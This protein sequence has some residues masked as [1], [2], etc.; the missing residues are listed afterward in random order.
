MV[1]NDIATWDLGEIIFSQDQRTIT[2]TTTSGFHAY[3]RLSGE[4]VCEGKLSSLDD[5]LGAHWVHE[6]SLQF[7]ISSKTDR[8]SMVSIKE[9]Q[10][11]SDP[12]LHLV[13]SFPILPQDGRFSF[14]PVSFHVSFVSVGKIVI[15][16]AQDSKILFQ[17]EGTKTSYTT[18]GYF[19]HDGSFCACGISSGELC[20]WK[21]TSTGYMLW[22]SL[23]PRFS[24]YQFSWSPTSVTIL[25]CSSNTIQLLHPDNCP[26][27]ISPKVAKHGEYTDHLVAYSADQTHIIIG[28]P[29]GGLIT[30]LDLL[31]TMQQSF[32][33]DAM[34]RDIKIVD[35]MIFV[36]EGNRLSSWHLA[37]GGHVNSACGIKRENTTLHVRLGNLLTL[38]NDCSEIAFTVGGAAFLYS[39]Q[40]QKVLGNLV[41]D[42]DQVAHIQFSPDGSQLWFIVVGNSGKYKCY[43]V[44]LNRTKD[45]CFGN[46]TIEDLQDEWSLD[47]IF[48]S[49][50]QY[51][52]IGKRSKWISGPRGNVLWLPVNWRK[53]HGLNTRWD[54]NFLALL[55]GYHPEPIIIEF[56]P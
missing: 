10:P 35:N 54:G 37:I 1:I 31:G 5:R 2:L 21:N 17:P 51:R 33:I 52:I 4:Q 24:W 55:S 22:S 6:Q 56:Q 28:Q 46:V 3:D 25:C 47:S 26:S 20:I 40:A 19:S 13:K 42:C 50:D 15:L 44:E 49:P 23:R 38:S 14:S 36:V 41:T 11:T 39:V 8:E 12:P 16:D 30:A 18:A 9:L 43:H 53:E 7:A 34:I 48:R 45:L 29:E 27:P 32:S